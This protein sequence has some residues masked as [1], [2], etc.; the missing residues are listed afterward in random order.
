MK[1]AQLT[2]QQQ[3]R[4]T[5]METLFHTK[6]EKVE[7]QFGAVTIAP[8]ERVPTEGVSCHQENEY[9]FIVKGNISGE[10]GGI[11]FQASGGE[12]TFIPANEEHWAINTSDEPCEIVWALVKE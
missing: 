11:P 10:S 1:V 9:S 4:Q 12:A 8:G 6:G 5:S 2:K 7:V 3:I